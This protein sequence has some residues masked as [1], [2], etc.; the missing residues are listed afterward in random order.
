MTKKT[1]K[2]LDGELTL[3]KKELKDMR[4]MF[5]ALA[6]KY[7]KLEKSYE[8]L[9]PKCNVCDEVFPTKRNLKRHNNIQHMKP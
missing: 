6:E 1:I 5:D 8:L 9:L 4:G 7:A 2:D 3:V